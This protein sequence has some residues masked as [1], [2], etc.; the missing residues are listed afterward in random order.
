MKW[1][2]GFQMCFFILKLLY[3]NEF[4]FWS[5]HNKKKKKKKNVT[6]NRWDIAATGG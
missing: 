1:M 6:T 3:A 5:L 4:Q 2:Q